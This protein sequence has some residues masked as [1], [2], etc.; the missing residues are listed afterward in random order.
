MK[1]CLPLAA[2][3]ALAV[4]ATADTAAQW[5][6]PE[7]AQRLQAELA[8]LLTGAE[9]RHPGSPGNLA[10]EG[11]VAEKFAASGLQHGEM[12]FTAPVFLPGATTLEVDGAA[13]LSVLPMHPTLFRPGNFTERDFTAPLVYAGQGAGADLE[14]LSGTELK[15]AVVVMEFD[16]GGV[17]LNWLRFGVK[18]FI[19]LEP[20]E[21]RRYEALTKVYATEVAVPRFLARGD[22]ARALREAAEKNLT[23]R[24]R[25]EPSRWE[26]RYLRNLWVL[27]PG[28]DQTLS[29]EVA[30]FIA[31]MDANCVAPELAQGAQSAGNLMLLLRMLDLFKSAPPARSVLF[32]AVNAHTQNYKGERI[33][34]WH[35]LANRSDVEDLRDLLNADL[36]NNRAI[37]KHYGAL[38]L[39]SFRPED[40]ATLIRWR[41]MVDDSTGRNITI[42][43]P[44]VRLAKRDVNRTKTELGKLDFS[45]LSPTDRAARRAELE[46]EKVKY[47]NIL[48]LF[49]KVGI[50]TELGDLT[51]DE[52]NILRGYV[53]EILEFNR[54]CADLN[55]LELKDDINNGAIRDAIRGRRVV[56]MVNFAA[57]WNTERFGFAVGNHLGTKRWASSWGINTA[58]IST[59]LGAAAGG[60][61]SLVAD[62]LSMRGGLSELHYI[63]LE[64][65][66]IPP[67]VDI[68][69]TYNR[70]P[71]FQFANLFSGHGQA[72]L[73][74]DTLDNLDAQRFAESMVFLPNFWRELLNDRYVTSSSQ[75]GVPQAPRVPAISI[76][77]K[78]CKY[79]E[80]SASVF[81]EIPVPNTV[82]ILRKSSSRW[83]SYTPLHLGQIV[84]G[85]VVNAT[86]AISD[87]RAIVVLYGLISDPVFSPQTTSAFHFDD[88]F[89]KVDHVIN[90]G[91]SHSKVDSDRLN[92]SSTL[93]LFE[94]EEFPLYSMC[95]S[96]LVANVPIAITEMM[97][98]TARGNASPRNFGLTGVQSPLTTK[99]V[100]PAAGAPAA[101]YMDGRERFKLVTV[102]KRVMLNADEEEPE[103][104][105]V[106]RPDELD[107]DIFYSSV[108][109]VSILNHARLRKLRDV[110][111][112]LSWE[113]LERGDK[114]KEKVRELRDK[115]QHL[116]YLRTLYESMGAQM[117][118]YEQA[119]QT[120]DD[121]LKAVVVYMALLLPFCFFVQKL[122]FNFVKIEHEM[123][124]FALLFVIT[125]LVFRVIHPAFRVAQVAEAIFIAFVMGAMGLFVISILRGRFEGEMQLLFR[126]FQGAVIDDDV[127]YSTVT[128]KAMLIG[129]NN[130]KRRRIRTMLT[131]ATI[132]LIAFTMLS[133][134]SISKKINP[135]IVPRGKNAP[136]TGLMYHWPGKSTMDENSLN[137]MRNLLTDWGQ[138]LVRRWFV[139][140]DDNTPL[141]VRKVGGGEVRLD[142]ILGLER[143]EDGFVESLPLTAGRNF[144]ADDA[145]EVMLFNSVAAV[146]GVTEADMQNTRILLEGREYK[147][148]GLLDD[149]LF[150]H[151]KD[152]N[153]LPLL[154]IKRI[155]TD[156]GV[157]TF[158]PA[159][160]VK[161][162]PTEDIHD[163][164]ALFHVETSSLLVMPIVTAERLG[165]RP[166]SISL[167]IDDDKP[168]WSLVD[169]VLTSTSARFY[170]ASRNPFAAGEDG[171][172]T[173]AAGI[174]YIGSSYSTSVGGLAVLLIPLIIASTIILNTMLGSVYERKKEIA[175]YN[176][177]GLN[178]HHIGMFFLA[179]SFVYGVIGSVGGYLIGQVLSIL[180][181]RF[182]LVRGINFNY[183]SMSVAYVIIFTIAIVL[184][185]TIYPATVAT[186]AAVPSGKRKWSLPPRHGNL[187]PVVFPFVY[188]PEVS[189]GV[190]G[191][192]REYF[193]RFT[194]ASIGDLIAT[195][196]AYR[197]EKDAAGRPTFLLDYHVA[198]APYDLG[199]T[200]YLRFRLN[201][202]EKVQAYRL[203]MNI[204]RI[205]GQDTN[206]VTTNR[207]F[208]ERMRKYLMRWRSLDM[209]QQHV[210]V[211]QADL[212]LTA[213][214][215]A[216][217]AG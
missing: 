169:L 133:F 168:L 29:D 92:M 49:N 124:M 38:K 25:S 87:L 187:M 99:K 181:A 34:G 79:D 51:P 7:V 213:G 54:R 147:V 136:Y 118:C 192:L 82:V 120:T 202:D 48:T 97:A 178:P 78:T 55:S 60:K 106:L 140:S 153:D 40:E 3:W 125:F 113:F 9:M 58:E 157:D 174:Y 122:L 210:Y 154:P 196:T 198:L 185:S 76:L 212:G 52:S 165:A 163:M 98:L 6:S 94:C 91:T 115:N 53:S 103:G 93:A 138:F 193:S 183:S 68:L 128:Q 17:W 159:A 152:L 108:K 117:K 22:A 189:A 123:G 71:A 47:V 72:F 155:E 129:V 176:A 104:R 26:N 195:P 56:F 88:D 11:R 144:S 203:S 86:I 143:Q 70:T 105:G 102:D 126:S 73:P 15:G 28:S 164:G 33:L 14:R 134:T 191:Y 63:P 142:G 170:L 209:A 204:E 197:R 182:D 84:Y 184:L 24:V 151:I 20:T 61:P 116:A 66:N 65:Q 186:R 132:V 85:D 19:F 109:D 23:A 62:T 81:P 13:P 18:G 208:L 139:T 45:N 107:S 114:L 43:N 199:V 36:R 160:K 207:P 172:Q 173:I 96:T 194:A 64:T 146:L 35:L 131:T 100:D 90:A 83:A 95:D 141:C 8:S 110:A 206:W 27:V 69:Q 16:C 214:A 59:R 77:I 148:A 30:V 12:R 4:N 150:R 135:T 46:V 75:L 80:L 112:D 205:S 101:Y 42:K 156:A 171:R 37:L 21:Y 39:D 41:S 31:P 1:R 111:G 10:M 200:Q 215:D 89:I 74:T 211:Q 121:M 130:M 57:D 67:C 158:N 166:Y 201:Y 32:V 127:G 145:D 161:T 44:L 217:P 175:V 2:A 190:I 188:T 149:A 177:I 216:A 180:I 50:Q 179:E 167:K 119:K 162:S 137:V 5:A